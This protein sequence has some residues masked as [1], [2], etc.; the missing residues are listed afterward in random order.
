MANPY[1]EMRK[2]THGQIAQGLGLQAT[3]FIGLGLF[4]WWASGRDILSFVSFGA[5]DIGLGIALAAGMIFTGMIIFT[6]FPALSEK[7]VRMQAE[8]Y[9][10]LE[11]WL[12]WPMI[13]FISICAGFGE[14][15]LFRGGM[16]TWLGDYVPMWLAI[17]ASS[18]VFAVIHFAKPVIAALIFAIGVFFGIAYIW[19]GS[20]LA[21]MIAHMLYDV[22][23]LWFL[24][25]EMHRLRIFDGTEE[26]P[27]H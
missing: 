16:Q 7:L 15:A 18:A 2:M 21:V 9:A 22:Y 5:F 27:A 14:E 4:M 1:E 26:A 8:N 23:A 17:G 25:K 24:Q 3:A 19:S 12:G 10:F 11:N 13:I 20:L 6:S